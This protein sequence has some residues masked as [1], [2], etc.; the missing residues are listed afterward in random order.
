MK[1]SPR[2]PQFAKPIELMTAGDLMREIDAI[3]AQRGS[4]RKEL[5]GLRV[6]EKRLMALIAKYDRMLLAATDAAH[7]PVGQSQ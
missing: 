3:L 7:Q 4:T 1:T 5:L 2:L 6:S